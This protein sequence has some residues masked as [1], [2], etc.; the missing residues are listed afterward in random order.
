MSERKREAHQTVFL[1]MPKISGV[2]ED[3]WSHL[4]FRV[5]PFIEDPYEFAV[6]G[7]LSRLP[8]TEGN[9]VR[10]LGDFASGPADP[11]HPKTRVDVSLSRHVLMCRIVCEGEVL[12]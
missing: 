4:D 9:L 8:L 6:D 5:N 1:N 3:K 10:E 11:R 7:W 2:P 12:A